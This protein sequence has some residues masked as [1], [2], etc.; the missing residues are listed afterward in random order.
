MTTTAV[1]TWT[2]KGDWFDVC[3]CNVVCPCTFAQAPTGNHW[4]AARMYDWPMTTV[5]DC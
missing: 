2:L 1:P 5:R 3:T 4:Y